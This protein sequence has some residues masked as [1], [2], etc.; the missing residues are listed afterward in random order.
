MRSNVV[1]RPFPKTEPVS[2]I[3][4][5]L[6][7]WRGD[8]AQAMQ[9]ARFIADLQARHSDQADFLFSGRFDCPHDRDAIAYVSKKFNTHT[10]ISRQRARGWP[11]GPNVLW[12]E[13]M[14]CVQDNIE[15][16]KFPHYK[17]VLTFEADC[18][19]MSPDWITHFHREFDKANERRATYVMGA[20]LPSPGLHIN[21]NALFKCDLAFMRWLTKEVSAS[22][23]SMGWDYH[24]ARDFQKWGWAEMPK[25]LS[26]WGAKTLPEQTIAE[27]FDAGTIFFHG[28]K[29][30]SLLNA[31]RKRLL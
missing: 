29:D 10:Y 27:L 9:L 22:P 19:P 3:L 17:A 25:Q 1:A 7:Y 21:G 23:P 15:K 18:V 8:Q 2:K 24:L 11:H 26:W 14:N 30:S 12:Y 16:K 5:A 20:L 13:T 4:L 28:C 31:A 6:Q